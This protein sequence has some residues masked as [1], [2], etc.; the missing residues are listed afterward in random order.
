MTFA[1][2]NTRLERANI[3]YAPVNSPHDLVTDHHLRTIKFLH[4]V[5]APDGRTGLIAALPVASN[6]WFEQ[7]RRDPPPLGRD[8]EEVLSLINPPP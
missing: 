2:A 6:G 3:P 4:E 7:Q 5:T 1:L 8:T